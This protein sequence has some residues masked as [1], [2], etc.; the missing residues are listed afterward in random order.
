MSL[1]AYQERV[2]RIC[3][4]EE[5]ADGDLA[6][7]VMPERW[8]IYRSM[9]RARLRSVLA[10]GLPQSVE[11]LGEARFEGAFS[12]WLAEG[13]PAT[14]YFWRVV[15]EFGRWLG[16]RLTAEESPESLL[17][18][19]RFEETKWRVRYRE[20]AAG[21]AAVEFNFEG[22]PYLNPSLELCEFAHPVHEMA[23][24]A[25]E[26]DAKETHLALYR[27]PDTE[28]LSI[29]RLNPAA[30]ALVRCWRDTELSMTDSVKEV[31]SSR[32]GGFDRAFIEKLGGLLADLLERGI[33]LGSHE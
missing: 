31:T 8:L 9:V 19:L 29:Y 16:E 10:S 15:P 27:R 1:A 20:V 6:E 21:A 33:L 4:D 25:D 14:R 17:E 32:G 2:L 18:Q 24:D 11:R 3:F 28:K 5:P 22:R 26:L 13:G 12:A 7:M 23:T 30:A